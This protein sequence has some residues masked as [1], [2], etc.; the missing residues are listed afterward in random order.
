[1]TKKYKVILVSGGFDPVH[2]GH[3]EC[4]QNAK[5]LA[6]KVWIGLNNDDWLRRKKGKPFMKEGERKF[7]MES[8]RDVDW[9]YVMYP[10]IHNDDT[11]CDFI[12][13]ARKHY[14]QEYGEYALIDR[15]FSPF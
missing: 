9:A 6:D 12:D 13:A 10:K 11:A 14:I 5:K 2:K 1:M 4:I 3:I 8:L 15:I 7:I